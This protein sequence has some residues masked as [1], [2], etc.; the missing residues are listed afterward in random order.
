MQRRPP[1]P[2]GPAPGGPRVQCLTGRLDGLVDAEGGLL[3][4][5]APCPGL[6]VGVAAGGGGGGAP[7]VVLCPPGDEPGVGRVGVDADDDAGPA[8]GTR[9]TASSRSAA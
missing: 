7:R 8:S 5:V 9:R 4:V 3:V 1:A 2:V 6:P